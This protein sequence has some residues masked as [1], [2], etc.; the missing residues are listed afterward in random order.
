MSQRSHSVTAA[1]GCPHL[2]NKSSQISSRF[3]SKPFNCKVSFT[4]NQFNFR[5]KNDGFSSF[6]KFHL[7]P[8]AASAAVLSPSPPERL[9]SSNY[10]KKFHISKTTS[11]KKL[12]ELNCE[13]TAE[14]PD[15]FAPRSMGHL[16]RSFRHRCF[17]HMVNGCNHFEFLY[18]SS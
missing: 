4:F 5:H 17:W 1:D 3:L 16:D 12:Q 18:S 14:L 7:P 8:S 6:H 2:T 9:F 13:I 15:H 11:E 10:S